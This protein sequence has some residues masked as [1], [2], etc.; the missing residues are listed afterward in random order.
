MA[1]E[2]HGFSFG[3]GVRKIALGKAADFVGRRLET[4]G[5]VWARAKSFVLEGCS[6]DRINYSVGAERKSGS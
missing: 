5:S 4:G 1:D 6:G 2:V 3:L